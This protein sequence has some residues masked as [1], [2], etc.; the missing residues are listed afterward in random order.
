MSFKTCHSVLR[1]YGWTFR[2]LHNIHIILAGKKNLRGRV[3]KMKQILFFFWLV[4]N[5]TKVKIY[6][7]VLRDISQNFG[8]TK[9]LVKQKI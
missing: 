4:M 6:Q 9:E 2:D 5:K 1:K 3:A 7:E 8:V